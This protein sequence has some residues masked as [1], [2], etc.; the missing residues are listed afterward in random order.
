MEPPLAHRI[1]EHPI[2]RTTR[3]K[4]GPYDHSAH[5]VRKSHRLIIVARSNRADVQLITRAIPT[6]NHG[7]I[8]LQTVRLGE[9]SVDPREPHHMA[10][11][12]LSSRRTHPCTSDH[13]THRLRLQLLLDLTRLAPP[14][15]I[16]ERKNRMHHLNP[17]HVRL[18]P[19]FL[20]HPTHMATITD[21][22]DE[23]RRKPSQMKKRPGDANA[24]RP[25]FL[26]RNN[27]S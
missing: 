15:H 24:T 10:R 19:F 17:F 25:L 18:R 7:R 14:R 6:T 23:Q 4:Y 1:C 22:Q 12:L 13:T 9:H 2:Y 3:N 8:R 20:P 27:L 26:S 21:K 5:F 11:H 16:I